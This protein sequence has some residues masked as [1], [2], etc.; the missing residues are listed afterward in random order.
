MTANSAVI[1]SYRNYYQ[2]ILLIFIAIIP[3]LT[4]MISKYIHTSRILLR[5]WSSS[6]INPFLM[7]GTST[8]EAN[9]VVTTESESNKVKNKKIWDDSSDEKLTH[10]EFFKAR[11]WSRVENF[12]SKAV[13]E[14][15]SMDETDSKSNKFPFINGDKN[16]GLTKL[17]ELN[18]AGF[19]GEFTSKDPRYVKRKTF[20]I[21]LGYVG[22]AYSGYQRQ[23]I[24]S[25]ST[26]INE[27]VIVQ[28]KVLTVEDDIKDALGS[29]AY[30]AGRTDK[31]VSAI[32]QIVCFW[33]TDVS[34][35]END[36][37]NKFRAGEG[38]KTGR[39]SVYECYR[40]PKKF[41]ARSSATWRRYLYLFPL[42]KGSYEGGFDID[43]T[44]VDKVLKK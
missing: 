4:P 36:I 20:A 12:W 41:N 34:I 44:F 1:S 35:T 24:K 27:N 28:K 32:S 30:G 18:T 38:Y 39:L 42:N 11:N 14:P 13:Q 6:V 3:P 17:E 19:R 2:T 21:R 10:L 33:S 7:F 37:L 15:H 22:T 9:I 40:V 29:V 23:N 5:Q 25:S 43:V 8:N 26:S 31:G 16:Y